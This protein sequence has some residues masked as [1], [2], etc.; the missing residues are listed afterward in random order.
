MLVVIVVPKP[1]ARRRMRH[2]PRVRGELASAGSRVAGLDRG[3]EEGT[4]EAEDA[5]HHALPFD[6]AFT[7]CLSQS[8]KAW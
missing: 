3:A 4:K 8:R 5:G 2:V 6:E 7:A 1:P